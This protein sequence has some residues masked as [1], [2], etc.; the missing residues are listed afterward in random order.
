FRRALILNGHGGN[1]DTMHL[2]LRQLQP[3]YPEAI[4]GA[5]SYWEIAEREI[6]ERL[7]GSRKSVGHACAAETCLM[8]AVR[9]HLVRRDQIRDD[10]LTPPPALDGIY[11]PTDFAA[12]ST[13]GAIGYPEK[14]TPEQGKAMLAAIIDRVSAAV[15]A[16]QE[17]TPG[18]LWRQEARQ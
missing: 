5:G 18:T 17:A 4:L 1:I 16:M 2:A 12:R 13:A 8:M 9:P 10:H 14:A 11:F 7:T 3:D 15:Q 6:A